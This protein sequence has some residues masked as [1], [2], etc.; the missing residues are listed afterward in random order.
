MLFAICF[1]TFLVVLFGLFGYGIISGDIEFW[2]FGDPWGKR[3]REKAERKARRE[4]R[5]S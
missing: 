2:L 4:A 5:R 3:E 1:I